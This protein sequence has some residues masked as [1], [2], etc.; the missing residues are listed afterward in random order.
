MSDTELKYGFRYDPIPWI[1]N[2]DS[3]WAALARLNFLEQPRE[4]DDKIIDTFIEERLANV[5]PEEAPIGLNM[6]TAIWGLPLDHEGLR[7]RAVEWLDAQLAAGKGIGSDGVLLA[8]AIGW[9][10]EGALA[11]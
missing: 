4:G 10:K 5:P 8:C 11:R 2:D 6:D 7:Q 1:E 3:V 9:E